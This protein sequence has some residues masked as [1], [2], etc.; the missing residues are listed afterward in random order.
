[1]FSRLKIVTPAVVA[2]ALLAGPGA[3]M[4]DGGAVYTQTNDPTGNVVQRFDR[5]HD[6]TLTPAG[7]F[8]TGG[9][10]LAGLGGRQGAVELS[11]SERTV[12]AVN[13]GSDT[14][15]SL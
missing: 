12:Y 4:A 2:A 13:A 15:T 11:D 1:M 10:G 9:V 3:T 7:A 6:G 8:A 14:I 5:A